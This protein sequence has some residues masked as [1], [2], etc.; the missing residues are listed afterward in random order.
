MPKCKDLTGKHF[1]YLTVLAKTD[2]RKNG[3]V[4]WLCKCKCGN[5]KEVTSGDLNSGRVTSC[6]CYN[7][8]KATK[9][10]ID[11][12][13]QRFGKLTVLEKTEKRTH[14]R[15]VIWKCKC[16]CGNICEISKDSLKQGTKSCGCL[17]KEKA[18]ENFKEKYGYDLTGQHFGKLI[19]LKLVEDENERTWL[20]Q[21]ECGNQCKVSSKNLLRNHTSSCGCLKKSLGEYLIAKI[22]KEN[23]INFITQ[24]HNDTCKFPDTNY[25]A[26]FDFYVK[27]KYIIEFDGE[28]HFNPQ[29]FNN[30]SQLDAEKQFKKTQEHDKYKNQWCK[31]NNIPLIRIPYIHLKE[32]TINDLLLETSTFIIEGE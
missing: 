1:N 29:C 13:G 31:Q 12:S 6:G 24:Y 4:I 28:Q 21:C 18:R 3:A 16:D 7:K 30:I 8:E 27:N 32:L 15:S 22:L 26:Y 19:P 20:C 17:Q 10:F 14:N 23:N 25:Y 2:K 11:I 9:N 5:F